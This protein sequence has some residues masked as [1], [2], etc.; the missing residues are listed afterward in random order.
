M[1]SLILSDIIGDPIDL[2]SSGPTVP[3]NENMIR[4]SPIEIL[5]SLKLSQKVPP[6]LLEILREKGHRCEDFK[7][8][9]KIHIQNEIIANNRFFLNELKDCF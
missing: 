3:I 8:A 2:I 9:K 5:E 7:K 4:E 6:N 1:V